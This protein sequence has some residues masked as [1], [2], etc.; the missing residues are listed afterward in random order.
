MAKDK[1]ATGNGRRL[2]RRQFMKHSAMLSAGALLS[3]P[4][5]ALLPGCR[6]TSGWKAIAFPRILLH[7]FRLFDGVTGKL[8][9]NL[10][11]QVENGLIA[12]IDRITDIDQFSDHRAIDLKGKT[13]MPGLIDNHVH[14][15]VPMMYTINLNFVKQMNRQIANNFRACVMSGVTTVR[16]VGGFPA[17]IIKYRKLSDSSQIPGPRVISSLSPIAARKGSVLGAPEQAPYF[18]NPLVKWLLGGNYAERPQTV[19]EVR[20]TSERMVGL[21]AQWIKSLHQDHSYSHRP[22]VLPNHSDEGYRVILETGKKHGLK[23][24]L[25]EPLVSGFKKGVDL[26]FD[27]LEHMPM[28]ALIP[29][30]A[31]EKFIRQNMAIMPTLMVYGDIFREE[32]ILHY[33]ETRG[34]TDLVAESRNQISAKLKQTLAE[35]RGK[36]PKNESRPVIL[37]RQYILDQH[38]T[39]VKNL[40]QLYSM[41]AVVGA[42][43]DLGG[44]YTAVFGRYADEIRR[45]TDAGIPNFEALKM[46][47]S[48]NAKILGMDDKI[49]IVKK[50]AFAD[51]IAVDGDPLTDIR[52]LEQVRLV[53]KGGNILKGE[54]FALA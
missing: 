41:G 25:H 13:L 5:F 3:S 30:P 49:G 34:R 38:P 45:Y 22:R 24:A 4:A 2:S 12:H 31:I 17:K 19:E 32:E 46:A 43:T 51:L 44:S 53:M 6:D 8:G 7:N 9:E 15:T 48:V 52:A 40:Q 36:A 23:C 39:M 10:M 27:T 50:G 35:S 26:G 14:M 1:T 33:I 11:V 18:L 28:D 20:E 47:T 42:G 54:G 29:E 16:D 21:G 37:D